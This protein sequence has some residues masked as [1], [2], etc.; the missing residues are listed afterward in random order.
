MLTF[1]GLSFG[2]SEASEDLLKVTKSFLKTSRT[3]PERWEQ[4]KASDFNLKDV[5]KRSELD[6]S[7]QCFPWFQ[8]VLRLQLSSAQ[9]F[10]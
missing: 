4:P 1:L 2:S 8:L 10:Q 5:V 7:V 3:N 6:H 9:W